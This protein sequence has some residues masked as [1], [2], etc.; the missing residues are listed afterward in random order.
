[1]ELLPE[2]SKAQIVAQLTTP[3]R[4]SGASIT[5]AFAESS[6]SISSNAEWLASFSALNV[7]QRAA[8]KLA[9]ELWDDLVAP[10]FVAVADAPGGYATDIEFGNSQA[11]TYALG[12]FPVMGAVWINDAKP[13][14]ANPG[15]GQYGFQTFVHEIG[16]AIGLEHAGDYGGSLSGSLAPGYQQDSWAYSIMSYFGPD[17]WNYPGIISADWLNAAGKLVSPQTPMLNDIRA[18]QQMYGAETTT[19]TETTVYGFNSTLSG[20]AAKIFDFSQN[21]DPVLTIYDAGGIDTL[22]LSEWWTPASIDLHRGAFSSANNMTRNI[23]IADNTLIENAVGGAGRDTLL[24]N[25]LANVLTGGAGGDSL[26]GGNGADL[27]RGDGGSEPDFAIQQGISLGAGAMAF[28]Y[29]SAALP[30]KEITVECLLEIPAGAFASYH[31]GALL[32]LDGFQLAII[33]R[34][35]YVGVSSADSYVWSTGVMLDEF[36]GDGRAH[37]LSVSWEYTTGNLQVYIDGALLQSGMSIDGGAERISSGRLYLSFEETLGDIRVYDRVL[38][39]AEIQAHAFVEIAD[40][41]ADPTLVANW[42]ARQDGGVLS[43]KDVIGG[44][45][46]SLYNA[47]IAPLAVHRYD[48]LLNGGAGDDQLF[49]ETGSDTLVG[50]TGNDTLDG[51]AGADRLAGGEG[52]DVYI[53]DNPLD[54]VIEWKTATPGDMDLVNSHL[55]AYVLPANVE[56]GAIQ[57]A[58]GASLSG[59]S[60]QNLLTGGDGPDVLDGRAGADTLQGGDG[61]DHF[62]QRA[63]DSK[64][65]TAIGEGGLAAGVPLEFA[66][67]LDVIADFTAGAGGDELDLVLKGKPATALGLDGNA[68]AASKNYFL[69]GDWDALNSAFTLASDGSGSSTLIIQTASGKTDLLVNTSAVLLVGVDSDLLVS[70]NFV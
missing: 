70:A 4:W 41:A 57:L 18:I 2:W 55:A 68:L 33:G 60:L 13:E 63:A 65:A 64:A 67:G 39:S 31:S 43:L 42:Q 52:A 19:R 21:P 35:L 24:G 40:P 32:D 14:L 69:S 62:I 53:V 46:F 23:A 9:L 48:D 6:A 66:A 12:A 49:G 3:Y 59:N 27:L 50:A 25:A 38:S 15:V 34:E 58:S 22:D 29:A 10:D 5:Y 8:A 17:D 28:A 37:R 36:M 1:M 45:Q 7:N 51:G 20:E 61:A 16:H 26:A 44:G 47:G 11:V 30:T 56:Q 54:V